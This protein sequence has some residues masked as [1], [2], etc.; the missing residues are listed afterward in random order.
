MV[1]STATLSSFYDLAD[2]VRDYTTPSRGSQPLTPKQKDDACFLR[3]QHGWHARH[4][5]E[6]MGLAVGYATGPWQEDIL[7]ALDEC[8]TRSD[9]NSQGIFL[10]PIQTPEGPDQTTAAGTNLFG[11]YRRTARENAIIQA[12]TAGEIR[13]GGR[14]MQPAGK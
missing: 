4:I 8:T 6:A 7:E 3:F 12:A 13:T 9:W 10:R 1:F 5:A 11:D 14:V 2:V